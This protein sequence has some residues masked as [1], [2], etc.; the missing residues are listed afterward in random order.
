MPVDLGPV[1]DNEAI[2]DTEKLS[3][4]IAH[5]GVQE[6]AKE[7]IYTPTYTFTNTAGAV[8][9]GIQYVIGT[10]P[11]PVLRP[12]RQPLYDTVF[13]DGKVGRQQA[14]VDNRFFTDHKGKT[15]QDT[16]LTQS[17][18][19]G[20]PLEFDL[21]HLVLVFQ[22][23]PSVD[24]VRKLLRHL[25]AVWF[26]GAN[27]PWLRASFS[28]LEP[29]HPKDAPYSPSDA[30]VVPLRYWADMRNPVTGAV[31][32]ISSVESFHCDI[33]THEEVPLE[34][35]IRLQI[36]LMGILYAGL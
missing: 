17:G 15:T 24:A 26:F 36:V 23:Y 19:L 21:D 2:E 34:S 14:F 7:Y 28:S 35:P 32:R 6:L 22:E 30:S 29:W 31:R 3:Y 1:S 13:L 20:Y 10:P 33:E 25:T 12:L 4:K 16:N 27:V 9:T 11:T 18:Q 5:E 8:Y